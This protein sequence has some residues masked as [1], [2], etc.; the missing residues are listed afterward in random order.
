MIVITD[1]ENLFKRN[2]EGEKQTEREREFKRIIPIHNKVL[3]HNDNASKTK[4][5]L[6]NLLR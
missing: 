3:A 5:I 1:K 6:I 4:M 2:R